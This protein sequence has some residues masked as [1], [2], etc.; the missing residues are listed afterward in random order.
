MDGRTIRDVADAIHQELPTLLEPEEAGDAG[1]RLSD[2]LERADAG[3]DVDDELI[4]V[5]A[6]REETRA[7]MDEL[8]PEFL[9]TGERGFEPLPGY[10]PEPAAVEMYRCPQGDYEWPLFEAGEPVPDCPV[11]GL[12][13][14]R[15]EDDG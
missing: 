7:R 5:L 9:A 12:P 13:L 14:V 2:L 3:E 6:A 11:H 4:A 8:L 1:A 10:S 15:I